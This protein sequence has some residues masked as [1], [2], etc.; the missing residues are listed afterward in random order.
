MATMNAPSDS[1]HLP[2][3]YTGTSPFL[4]ANPH[5][6]R[7]LWKTSQ[8]C[9][10]EAF[11]DIYDAQGFKLWAAS[12]PLE[13]QLLEKL[14]D[15][16]LRKP[17]ELC[18]HA[19]DAAIAATLESALERACAQSPDLAA[20]L[21]THRDVVLPAMRSLVLNPQERLLMSVMC[22]GAVELFN[23]ATVVTALA[24]TLAAESGLD[25]L[26]W[27]GLAQAALLHDVGQLY[28][29]TDLV[30]VQAQ[31]VRMTHPAVGGLAAVEL[32]GCSQEVGQLIACSHERLNGSGH[33]RGLV[34]EQLTQSARILLFAEAM[35]DYLANPRAGAQKAAI[36]ARMV[37][38]EFDEASVGW[39]VSLARMRAAA[40]R[41]AGTAGPVPHLQ[42]G[43]EAASNGGATLPIG[44]RLREFHG[45]LSRAVVLLSLPAGELPEVRQA[46]KRWLQRLNPLVR[47]L[48]LSGVED[49]LAQGQNL[50]PGSDEEAVELEM[51][52]A[53]LTSRVED[54][55]RN[56]AL[57]C[58]R[59]VFFRDSR[60]VDNLAQIVDS[61]APQGGAPT[62]SHF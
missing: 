29:S 52:L 42:G 9:T 1:R 48:R 3:F 10:V 36:A 25:A 16:P 18:V 37:P 43:E 19:K 58:S 21:A 26:H 33:P 27:S 2:P 11:E 6:I 59:S 14:T 35:A 57:E 4:K 8:R 39:I 56:L 38:R 32:A 47:A 12:K 50:E 40:A 28:F 51:L 44:L 49:A 13:P 55:A 7:L 5:F 46:A 30:G 22:H 23:H 45:G 15:R 34:A 24:L 31:S 61:L 62:V 41:A 17:I 53:E 20:A 60:L 54:F